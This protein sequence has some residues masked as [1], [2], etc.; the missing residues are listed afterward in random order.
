MREF[1]IWT[2]VL[3]AAAVVLGSAVPMAVKGFPG[4]NQG[5]EYP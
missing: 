1:I 5:G 3:I 2:V 4:K